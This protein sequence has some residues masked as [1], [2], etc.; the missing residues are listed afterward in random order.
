MSA[1][2]AIPSS[3]NLVAREVG[4]RVGRGTWDYPEAHC[5]T[6]GESALTLV[7]FLIELCRQIVPLH[8]VCHAP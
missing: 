2:E 6:V 5:G 4:R 3:Q 1:K 7:V 8:E